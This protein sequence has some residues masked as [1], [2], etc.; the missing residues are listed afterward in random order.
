MVRHIERERILEGG[1]MSEFGVPDGDSAL[2]I[3]VP[4]L[5]IPLDAGI[6]S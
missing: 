1:D 5:F 4:I 6:V 2:S 3:G